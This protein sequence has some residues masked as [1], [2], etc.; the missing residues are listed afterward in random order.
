MHITKLHLCLATIAV[1]NAAAIASPLQASAI[2]NGDVVVLEQE[3]PLF[4]ELLREL[5]VITPIGLVMA[6]I[7]D[8]SEADMRVAKTDHEFG[9]R[10]KVLAVIKNSIADHLG[11]QPGDVILELN[12]V[13]VPKGEDAIAQFVE[14]VLPQIDWNGVVSATILRDGFAQSLEGRNL[15]GFAT[16]H[17]SVPS[18]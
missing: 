8:F 6:N 11:L 10:L 16:A 2:E 4:Q 9:E 13:Y 15:S 12:N 7:Y 5:D 17:R 3:E 14:R 1:A 18:S